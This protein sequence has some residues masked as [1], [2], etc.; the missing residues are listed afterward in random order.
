M[1]QN[2]AGLEQDAR[3][4]EQFGYAQRLKRTIGSYTSFALGFSMVSITAAIFTVFSSPFVVGGAGIWLWVPITLGVLPI[5]AVYAHLSARLP[6]T[7]YAYQWS[8]RLVNRHYGWATGWMAMLAFTAGTAGLAV[9]I[10]TVFSPYLWAHPTP[11]QVQLLGVVI[12][13][14]AVAANALGVKIATAVNNFG[15]TAEIV[16]TFGLTAI[17]AI[18]L[19]FFKHEQGPH[20][21]VASTAFPAGKINLTTIALAALLPVYTLIGWEGS[22]DLA[23][24]TIDPRR[25]APKAMFRSVLVSAVGGF[26]VFA[27]FAMAIPGSLSGTFGG[28]ENPIIHLFNAQLGPFPG[29]IMKVV[30]FVAMTSALLANV[31]VAT[32]LIYSLS[33]DRLLP[34][35]QVLSRVNTRTETPLFTI[36]FV[37]VCALIVNF[38]SSGVVAKVAAIVSVCYYGTYLL[39]LIAVIWADRKNKIPHA[40]SQYFSVGRW[41]QPLAWVGIAF[42]IAV[43]AAE[44]V[45]KVNHVAGTYTLYALGIGLI[46]WAVYLARKLQRGEAGPNTA[47]PDLP[48]QDAT[49]RSGGRGGDDIEPEFAGV[50]SGR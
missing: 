15:A 23:E 16:G 17:L 33:R 45:P 11:V 37:G 25:V 24:E 2:Q 27:V 5:L 36:A 39:T 6:V 20:V 22:A 35:W 3:D 29:T 41:L 28:T 7:G 12:I 48:A 8:A 32:R 10:A 38:L 26:V 43:I 34:G 13:V 46:W 18:G 1:S 30:A 9:A 19:F 31:A 44:T 42:T 14:F 50:G 49:A 21:L 4:L 40:P 47:L